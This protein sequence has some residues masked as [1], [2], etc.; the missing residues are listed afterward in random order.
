[1]T[2]TEISFYTRLTI[3]YTIIFVI[4]LIV[5]KFAWNIGSGIYLSFFPPGPPPPT[6][7]WGKLPS[8]HFPERPGLPNFSYTLQTAT[9]ELPVFPLT[10]PVYFMPKQQISFLKLEEAQK[11]ANDLDFEEAGIP[12]SETIYRFGRK[13]TSLTLD[14]NTVNKTLSVNYRLSDSPELLTLKP[15]SQEEA[16]SE[17]KSLLSTGG[18]L[19]EDLQQGT[20]AYEYLRVEGDQLVAASSFSEANFVRVNFFRKPVGE[21]PVVTPSRKKATV[22]FLITGS[23]DRDKRIIAGEYHYFPI[24]PKQSSTYPLK[25]AQTAWDELTTGKTSDGIP[26][27]YIAHYPTD[28]TKIIIRKIYLAYY[29]SGTPQGFLQPVVVFEGD[30][31]FIAYVAAVNS[32]TDNIQ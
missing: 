27:V 30:G 20:I 19:A 23:E 31:G 9:G 22:W 11:L 17:A 14:V 15:R 29:D 2:L 10:M 26:R 24:D 21:I 8:L 12:L 32:E 4:L 1:M 18:L 28:N 3:K 13:N 6:I 7:L 16:A 25:T 5:G